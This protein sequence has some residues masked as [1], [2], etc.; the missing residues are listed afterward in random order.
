VYRFIFPV[1]LFVSACLLFIIQPM[2]AKVLLPVYGGTPAVWTVCMLFFQLLLLLAYSYA[3]VLSRFNKW[4]V[5]HLCVCLLSLCVLPLAFVPQASSGTPE[6]QILMGLLLQLGLPLLVVGASAPLLQFAYSQTTG[7]RAADPYFLY[8]ASNAGSLLALLSYPWLVERFSGVTQQFYG[9][10]ITYFVYLVFLSYLLFAVRYTKITPTQEKSI[11]IPWRQRALWIGLSFIPCSLMLGVTFYISTDI[12]ATP[13][14]WV[15]PLALYLLSFILTF[16]SKPIVSHA[17]VVRYIL[18][19]L[20]FPILGFIF[21]AN[22]IPALPLIAANLAG[23]FMVALLCHGELVHIRPPAQQL[24]LFYF[25]LSLG[26]V[27]AG[28]FNG[29]LAPRIFSHAYEYPLV[30][31]LALLFIPLHRGFSSTPT[32]RGLSAGSSDV[33]RFLDPADKPR[34]VGIRKP[35]KLD[36]KL[37]YSINKTWFISVCVLGLLFNYHLSPDHR[38][39][40]REVLSQKRNF[41]GIKQVFSQAGA[42]VLLSQSTMHGFQ[43]QDENPTDGAR[44]YYGS[45]FPVVQRLQAEHQPL[46]AMVL[47]LGTGIMACQFRAQD[48]LTMVEIDEQVIDIAGNPKLFTYLRDCPPQTDLIKDDGLLA[49]TRAAD[50]SYE[51]LVMDAF[52]SDAIPVHLLTLE[53]FTLYKQKITPDG[54]IMVNIS[55]RHLRVLP[56]LTGA[57]RELEMIVLHKSQ[58]ANHQLGQL[59]AEWALL[60]SNEDLAGSLLGE[61]WR[62][63]ADNDTRLWTNDYSNLIPLL[64]W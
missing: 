33:Q 64:R 43:V 36:I 39:Q 20:A 26:G 13:L 61:G 35:W 14:F 45:V 27:L 28:I 4:R 24:T 5:V 11:L 41:Y 19:F 57:G 15:L 58:A 18:I 44:A 9:W 8:V 10:N 50:T 21:G 49:A 37:Y 54:V 7:K 55:N 29:L 25:C 32:S 59:P 53:A 46:H 47:G 51:L 2:V 3:W 40:T 1:S 30:M 56:V 60:T 62:F 34:E 16:A 23:F 12:A 48:K 22:Q 31:L 63:V 17:W 42:H 6:I 38:L 52:N